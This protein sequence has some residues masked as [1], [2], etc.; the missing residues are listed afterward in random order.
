[1]LCTAER[2]SGCL[3]ALQ[4][5]VASGGSASHMDDLPVDA[6]GRCTPHC[7]QGCTACE[8]AYRFSVH[9]HAFFPEPCVCFSVMLYRRAAAEERARAARERAA[10]RHGVYKGGRPLGSRSVN[11]FRCGAQQRLDSYVGWGR[12]PL[13]PWA[14]AAMSV[15]AA[16][17]EGAGPDYVW[18]ESAP[19]VLPPELNMGETHIHQ[20][21]KILQ[22]IA[23]GAED[24]RHTHVPLQVCWYSLLSGR[25]KTGSAECPWRGCCLCPEA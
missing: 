3:L 1:M 9:T 25:K 23:A 2:V 14:T 16:A 19:Q 11:P 22:A 12:F 20:R 21:D 15:A 6:C 5:G 7:C 17:A 18:P 10:A 8:W 13:G 24:L 4:T